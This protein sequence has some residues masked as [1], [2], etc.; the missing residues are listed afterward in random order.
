MTPP[1]RV[2]LGHGRL[3]SIHRPKR[4][5]PPQSR[6]VL[7]GVFP[8]EPHTSL[9]L[10]ADVL[11]DLAALPAATGF[12]WE[13]VHFIDLD[14][15]WVSVRVQADLDACRVRICRGGKDL[16]CLARPANLTSA[17]ITEAEWRTTWVNAGDTMPSTGLGGRVLGNDTIRW[18]PD[19]GTVSIQLPRPLAHLGNMPARLGLRPPRSVAPAGV[20]ASRRPG[21]RS[22]PP[23]LRRLH[24]GTRRQTQPVLPHRPLVHHPPSNS[25]PRR[26]CNGARLWRWT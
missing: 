15:R 6:P 10:V 17:K 23:P 4:V 7:S 16:Q 11:G 19:T 8:P 14:A 21:H 12:G 9:A 25:H 22:G 3:R 18:D 20:H 1:P 2:P 13:P 24:P 5:A 26:S